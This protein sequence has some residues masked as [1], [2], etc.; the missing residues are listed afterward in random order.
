[1]PDVASLALQCFCCKRLRW[2]IPGS[3]G[4][5]PA[6]LDRLPI[7]AM[8]ANVMLEQCEACLAAGV[9][10]QLAKPIPLEA[11]EAKIDSVMR[12]A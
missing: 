2:L 3:I 6:P 5:L 11:L 8:T 1:M 7:V 10:D 4:A 12:V 9:K